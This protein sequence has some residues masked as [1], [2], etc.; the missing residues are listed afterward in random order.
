MNAFRHHQQGVSLL[1]ALIS[2]LIFAVGILAIVALQATS[3]RTGNEAKYRADA[4]YLAN[5]LIGRMWTDRANLAAYAHNAA[6]AFACD[7]RVGTSVAA[8]ANAS[9]NTWLQTVSATLPAGTNG[10]QRVVVNTATNLVTITMCWRAGN[11]ARDTRQ[12]EISTQIAG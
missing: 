11:D 2:I 4:S 7:G 6:G 8:P 1:E 12:F 3:I 5:Q 9:L 10:A